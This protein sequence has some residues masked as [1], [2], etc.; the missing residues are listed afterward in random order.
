MTAARILLSLVALGLILGACEIVY[1]VYYLG[2]TSCAL[3][4]R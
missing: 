2:E 1:W 3:P 4:V